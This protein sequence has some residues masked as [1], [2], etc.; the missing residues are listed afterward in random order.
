MRPGINPRKQRPNRW[1]RRK[2]L[3]FDLAALI[4]DLFPTTSWKTQIPLFEGGTGG[5][6]GLIWANMAEPA[7]KVGRMDIEYLKTG[8]FK[9]HPI[10]NRNHGQILNWGHIADVP[11]IPAMV[12]LLDKVVLTGKDYK[13]Y[14]DG[15]EI[16]PPDN[17]QPFPDLHIKLVTPFP[18]VQPGRRYSG[19][20][21]FKRHRP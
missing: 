8:I 14:L 21:T 2:P 6:T 15:V 18:D 1:Q 3:R 7:V 9:D 20:L 13:F 19:K 12:P 17:P 16:P 10:V 4:F 5:N 11:P